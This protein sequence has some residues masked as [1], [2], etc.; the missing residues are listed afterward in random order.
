MSRWWRRVDEVVS[1]VSSF[2]E[3]SVLGSV[4]RLGPE[5]EDV[6]EQQSQPIKVRKS[7]KSIIGFLVQ[8]SRPM[9][10]SGPRRRSPLEN[11][12]LSA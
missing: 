2:F 10:R 6:T 3:G 12:S 7:V 4:R 11:T 8:S 1:A 5:T 9:S